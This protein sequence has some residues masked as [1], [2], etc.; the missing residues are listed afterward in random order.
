VSA[1]AHE[2]AIVIAK[3]QASGEISD[4][5]RVLLAW[6]E[7]LQREA[8]GELGQLPR[9]RELEDAAE[10]VIWHHDKRKDEDF[11]WERLSKLIDEME[12]FI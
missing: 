12:E 3:L 5:I 11:D 1:R 2:A 9:L 4:A 6:I 10:K 8:D 7:E